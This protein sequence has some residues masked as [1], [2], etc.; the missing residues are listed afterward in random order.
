MPPR[1]FEQCQNKAHQERKK[2]R[3]NLGRRDNF[4]DEVL[5]SME[6]VDKHEMVQQ[7]VKSKNPLPSFVLFIEK[8]IV[9]LKY[10]VAH[11]KGGVCRAFNLGP[12]YASD[13]FYKKTTNCQER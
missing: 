13:L 12:F 4:A 3:S 11:Q 2:V 10:I 9:D 1:D 6:V 8:Q 7:V 5:D